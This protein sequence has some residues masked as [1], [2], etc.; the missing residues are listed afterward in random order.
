L[1]RINP[2]DPEI[3]HAHGISLPYGALETLT[4]LHAKVDFQ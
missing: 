3:R 1:I 4:A 2:H